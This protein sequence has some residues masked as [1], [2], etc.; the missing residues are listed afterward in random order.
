MTK[1]AI[2]I[3]A[4][5]PLLA[6]QDA[7]TRP[8]QEL[9]VTKVIHV[10]YASAETIKDLLFH[11]NVNA[12]ANNGL[13]ALVL[14]GSASNIAAAEQTV[15]ELDVPQVSDAAR[16]V[17]LTMYIVGATNRPG[18]SNPVPP[19]LAP[20]V[21]QLNAVFP[22]ASY[23]LLDTALV[24]GCEGKIMHMGGILQ[25]FP[26]A[27]PAA[28]SSYNLGGMILPR[29]DDAGDTIHL[30]NIHFTA[31]VSKFEAE[32]RTDFDLRPGPKVVVGKTNIDDGNSALFVVLTGKFV[33]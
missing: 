24:R 27:E 1:F 21:R 2:L 28:H 19:E 30:G 4:I 22:Y 29:T 25:S 5:S 33:Q 13:K 23:R 9:I 11:A 18:E 31:F 12:A 15:K 7:N 32:I 10:R 3:L 8:A 17:D 14:R 6:A 20:V 16:D 26:N